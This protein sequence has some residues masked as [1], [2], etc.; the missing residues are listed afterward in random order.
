MTRL[1]TAF[2]PPLSQLP[3]LAPGTAVRKFTIEE[4]HKLID[5]GFF[6][7]NEKFELLEGWIVAK[8]SRNPP[9]DVAIDKSTDAIR[10]RLPREWRVRVQLAVTLGDSEPEPDLAIVRSPAE[11]YVDHHP[12]ADDIAFVVESS[13]SSLGLD[14]ADKGRVYAAAGIAVYWILNVEQKKVEVYTDPTPV[15]DSATY[16]SLEV[17]DTR[18]GVPLIIAGQKLADIAVRELFP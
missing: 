17:F 4:Y 15:G 14:R 9:H 6:A 2:T 3:R 10:D 13:A 16:A 11:R 12:Y 5:L 7:A 1:V 8:M 18:D